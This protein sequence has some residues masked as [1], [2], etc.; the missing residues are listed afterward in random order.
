MIG[1]RK[2]GWVL[3]LA[4]VGNVLTLVLAVVLVK[5]ISQDSERKSCGTLAATIKAYVEVPPTTPAG[6]NVERAYREQYQLLGC[7][8]LTKEQER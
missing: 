5:N 3:L 7:P 8:R 2:V 1:E 4:V 6:K